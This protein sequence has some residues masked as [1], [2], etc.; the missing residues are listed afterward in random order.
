MLSTIFLVRSMIHLCSFFWCES[1]QEYA[2]LNPG[3]AKAYGIIIAVLFVI[4]FR[5]ESLV[6]ILHA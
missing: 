2:Y 5:E 4:W 1:L 6:G 3:S